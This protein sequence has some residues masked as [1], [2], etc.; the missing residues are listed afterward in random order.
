MGIRLM[1]LTH[2]TD[3]THSAGSLHY[4]GFAADLTLS[5]GT[6]EHYITT[7]RAIAVSL[8][9]DFDVINE[10]DHLHLEMQPKRPMNA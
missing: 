2:L 5:P 1:T 3:G 4:S 7:T 6:P 8:G 9:P 10:I